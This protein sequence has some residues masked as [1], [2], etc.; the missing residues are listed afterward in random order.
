MRWT[1]LLQFDFSDGS[2]VDSTSTVFGQRPALK[3]C[4]IFRPSTSYSHMI[5]GSRVALHPDS[6]RPV[7]CAVT[8]NAFAL[9][10]VTV[11][12]IHRFITNSTRSPASTSTDCRQDEVK[13]NLAL[14]AF[15]YL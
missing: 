10:M 7:K 6:L 9:T 15:W 8:A 5:M 2:A 3:V 12:A 1:W 13:R 14:V 4:Q 11:T